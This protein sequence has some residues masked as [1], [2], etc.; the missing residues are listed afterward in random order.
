MQ[1]SQ[2]ELSETRELLERME[3]QARYWKSGRRLVVFAG[4]ICLCL[5]GLGMLLL[6]RAESYVTSLLGQKQSVD[7]TVFSASLRYI[8]SWAMQ[9]VTFL[10]SGV[11]GILILLRD[12]TYWRR[13]ERDALFLRMAR[14]YLVHAT[15]ESK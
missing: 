12:L 8:K 4:L 2:E 9:M 13:R 3:K 14:Y 11:T 1:V 7:P 6:L 15:S 5:G 10:A